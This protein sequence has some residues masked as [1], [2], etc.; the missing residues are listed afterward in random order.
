V[1]DIVIEFKP[2]VV[3]VG[4]GGEGQA[5]RSGDFGHATDGGDTDDEGD[6]RSQANSVLG[7]LEAKW[8]N[9]NK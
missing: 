1:A 9:G 7:E 2:V 4:E 8:Y 6:M 5:V 3:A